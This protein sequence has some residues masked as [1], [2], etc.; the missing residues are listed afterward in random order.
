MILNIRLWHVYLYT[1]EIYATRCY[2]YRLYLIEAYMTFKFKSYCLL[3]NRIN[4][5]ADVIYSWIHLGI[6]QSKNQHYTS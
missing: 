3:W 2:D 6:W 1:N 5:N 4:E